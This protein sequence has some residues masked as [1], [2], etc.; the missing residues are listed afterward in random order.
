MRTQLDA[1]L[2]V[3]VTPKQVAAAAGTS[4]GGEAADGTNSSEGG[5]SSSESPYP[6]SE[7]ASAT[8]WGVVFALLG[9]GGNASSEV[10]YNYSATENTPLLYNSS[11][12]T[13]LPSSWNS[14]TVGG[15]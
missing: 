8:E 15:A 13:Y 11:S 1:L 14:S 3:H 12:A 4:S 5:N 9:P 7:H 10:S 6:S 2:T